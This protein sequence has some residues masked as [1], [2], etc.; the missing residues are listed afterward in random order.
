MTDIVQR[1]LQP[2]RRAGHH[3]PLSGSMAWAKHQSTGG[4]MTKIITRAYDSAEK[5]GMSGT[6]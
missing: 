1:L 3:A 5:P 4:N 6:N 2:T